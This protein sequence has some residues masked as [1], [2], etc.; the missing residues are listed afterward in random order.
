MAQLY[1]PA[2]L[3]MRSFELSEQSC[4]I[5]SDFCLVVREVEIGGAGTKGHAGLGQAIDG[6]RPSASKAMRLLVERARRVSHLVD[7]H[8]A[9]VFDGS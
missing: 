2:V 9:A 1:R 7:P 3:C 6:Q 4:K 8:P 5:V